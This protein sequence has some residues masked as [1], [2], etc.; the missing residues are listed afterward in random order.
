[1]R[2]HKKTLIL[3]FIGFLSHYSFAQELKE[4]E[5][6]I[7]GYIKPY[8]EMN[9]WSGLITM[10]QNGKP[11]FRK[12]YG[13]ADKEWEVKNSPE[14]KFRIASI[15]KVFTEVA[16]LQLVETG[17]IALDDPLSQFIPDYPRGN[18]IS[19]RQLVGHR[20]GIPHLNSFP[21]YNVL[22]K[23][24]YDLEEIIELFKH[25]PLD[26]EPGERYSYSNSGYV[27]L[28]A[29]I[30]KVSGL[31]YEEF[32]KVNINSK[33]GL[34]NTGVDSN[35][36]ILKNRARGYMFNENGVLINAEYVNMS[37]K[38]GGGSLYSTADDLN[39]FIQSLIKGK[40]LKS[41]LAELPNFGIIDG[42]DVF[43]AN[44]RV[45][46]FCH[47]ITHRIEEDMTIIVLGNHYSNIALPISQDIYRIFKNREYKTPVNYLAQ[48]IDVSINELTKYEGTYDFGF[49]PVG[50]VKAIGNNLGYLAPGRKTYDILIPIDENTFFYIQSWVIL[51]FKDPDKESFKTLEWIMGENAYPAKKMSN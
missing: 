48:K 5:T 35:A 3:L 30:E 42:K 45:Q 51:K 2:V 20:S 33:I 46:G 22:N 9:A 16:V 29:I 32:L 12:G 27:L 49:G 1:M 26:Y 4:L 34:S 19:I 25:R 31:S 36:K 18:E 6:K 15:S 13:Y 7:D 11:I 28:A 24:G 39:E 50:N 40:L 14:T 23:I 47:Q 10:Y 43:T 41:T 21:N 44:G 8:L 38:I 17:K 37:I